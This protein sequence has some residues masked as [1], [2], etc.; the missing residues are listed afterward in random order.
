MTLSLAPFGSKVEASS[1]DAMLLALPLPDTTVSVIVM[2]TVSLTASDPMSHVTLV[3]LLSLLRLEWVGRKWVGL[4][5][6]GE[7]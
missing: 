2:V 7:G 5:R 3:L 6:D 1:A 4:P